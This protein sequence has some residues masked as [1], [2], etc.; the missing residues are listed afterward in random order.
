MIMEK[1]RN[2][3]MPEN[4]LRPTSQKCKARTHFTLIELLIV[5]AII[6]IL[7]G[8]LLPALAKARMAS[9]KTGCANNLKQIGN[10]MTMYRNDWQDY[11]APFMKG[12]SQNCY[13]WDWAYGY[14]YMEGKVDNSKWSLTTSNVWKVFRCPEDHTVSD[15]HCRLSY[16]MLYTFISKDDPK[17][18]ASAFTQPS[19]TYVVAD[20]DH[21]NYVAGGTKY[22]DSYV[23]GDD[24]ATGLIYLKRSRSIGP[25][26]NNAAN[27][28]FL[29]GHA[30]ARIQWR[31]RN[32]DY[33]YIPSNPATCVEE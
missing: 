6:A 29:D 30:A 7:A 1:K 27:I 19:K 24:R 32:T 2:M 11:I 17:R 23:G 13:L 20:T 31:G 15:R 18:K 4:E 12:E 3:E 22:K 33:E 16:A 8:M 28:L 25:N 10:A 26:H 21:H 5:I 14:Y 9:E